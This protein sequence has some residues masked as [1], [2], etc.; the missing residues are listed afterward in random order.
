MLTDTE[1]L[2][3]DL[4][5]FPDDHRTHLT[6]GTIRKLLDDR[7]ALARK[8]EALEAERGALTRVALAF[9]EADDALEHRSR[10]PEDSHR[11]AWVYTDGTPFTEDEHSRRLNAAEAARERLRHVLSGEDA[12]R[13]EHPQPQPEKA[14]SP[15][16]DG[17][18]GC[19]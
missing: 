7:D 12:Q 6:A 1:R 16:E 19:S 15:P 14:A 5:S 4:E 13:S 9:L 18:G 17:K 8:V 11:Y 2:K 3:H 10:K